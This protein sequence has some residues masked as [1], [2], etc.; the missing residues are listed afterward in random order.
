MLTVEDARE[1]IY[2]ACTK[3]GITA[4]AKELAKT[5]I[6]LFD[7]SITRGMV[8]D[9]QVYNG[10]VELMDHDGYCYELPTGY[11]GNSITGTDYTNHAHCGAEKIDI[12]TAC[13]GAI[14]HEKG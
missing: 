13:E 3:S 2:T 10:H 8:V 9:G 4:A 6:D 11:Y 1:I 12:G 5:T 14:S 7:R